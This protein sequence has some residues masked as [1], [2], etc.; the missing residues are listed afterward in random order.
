MTTSKISF[1]YAQLFEHDA[2]ASINWNEFFLLHFNGNTLREMLYRIP[3]ECVVE[4]RA[5]F[6]ELTNQCVAVIAS[7]RNIK[8][9]NACS[10]LTSSIFTLANII[11]VS[12][13][14]LEFAFGE[15]FDVILRKL[16]ASLSSVLK[17]DSSM[18]LKII[19]IDTAVC[20]HCLAVDLNANPIVPYFLNDEFC[21]IFEIIFSDAELRATL[22]PDTM[23]VLALLKTKEH[24]LKTLME[25]KSVMNDNIAIMGFVQTFSV[26]IRAL[27]DRFLLSIGQ[28]SEEMD[29][30]ESFSRK[31]YYLSSVGVNHCKDNS[32]EPNFG[33]EIEFVL[34]FYNVMA[35]SRKVTGSLLTAPPVECDEGVPPAVQE[36]SVLCSLLSFSSYVFGDLKSESSKHCSKL[37]LLLLLRIADDGYILNAFH[38]V[39]LSTEVPLYIKPQLHRAGHLDFGD[40]SR[41]LAT[42]LLFLLAEFLRSHLTRSFLFDHYQV[43]LSVI[44]RIVVHERKC[45]LRTGCWKQLFLALMSVLQFLGS[46]EHYLSVQGDIFRLASQVM[47]VVNLFITYG[48]VLLPDA[49]SYD[50]LYY[51]IVRQ[52]SVFTRLNQSACSTIQKQSLEGSAENGAFHND[53]PS[54]LINQLMNALSIVNHITPKLTEISS[55][56]G[57]LSEEQVLKVVQE[58]FDSLNLKLYDGLDVFENFDFQDETSFLFEMSNSVIKNHWDRRVPIDAQIV[59]NKLVETLSIMSV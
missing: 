57:T 16:V 55:K 28:L 51:E 10:T 7:Q 15:E 3:P 39:A 9:Y 1:L 17:S 46:N 44:H 49:A 45:R 19:T 31:E 13:E 18:Y 43:A 21:S 47:V 6:S 40:P 2:Y 33:E 29:T 42:S 14:F 12:P 34:A 30:A 50:F 27:S 48:D 41:T 56:Q 22:G 11:G 32:E 37:C 35:C 23:K 54:K 5:A 8:F 58:S 25:M 20:I 59:Y 24:C 4:K 38:D 53:W 36:Q 52:H 26:W